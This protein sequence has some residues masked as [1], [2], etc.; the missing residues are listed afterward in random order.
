MP[1]IDDR[2]FVAYAIEKLLPLLRSAIV[3]I[4]LIHEA[5]PKQVGTGTLFRI[6]DLRLIVT[7]A[8][9]FRLAEL[10]NTNGLY[11]NDLVQGAALIPLNGK[12]HVDSEQDL[13]VLALS[14]K[15]V[16]SLLNREFLSVQVAERTLRKPHKGWYA[17]HGYPSCWTLCDDQEMSS[18]CR[19]YTR[20]ARLFSS[21]TE[22]LLGYD[23]DRHILLDHK[24]DNSIAPSSLLPDTPSAV[25]GIS[26]SSIWQLFRDG[27]PHEFWTPDEARIIAVETSIYK[28]GRIVKGT[29]WA[30]VNHIIHECFPDY[31]APLALMIPEKAPPNGD[32]E[33]LQRYSLS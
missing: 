17:I 28:S 32:L 19:P 5:F 8:H 13:A 1:Q 20:I 11:T 26:G 27:T 24:L 12:Y 30:F 2:E 21:S 23:E 6:A 31:R 9:V 22:S 18:T 10:E 15:Q 16:S 4:Y 3:P 7:A 14:D 29:R 25:G 33:G